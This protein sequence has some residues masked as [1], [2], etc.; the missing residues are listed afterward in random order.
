MANRKIAHNKK[1]FSGGLSFCVYFYALFQLV[2]I[3][4]QTSLMLDPL[5]F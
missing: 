2:S 3:Q 4:G 1:D 5:A